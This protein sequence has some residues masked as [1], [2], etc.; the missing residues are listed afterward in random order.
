M[1]RRRERSSPP[2]RRSRA[3][4]LVVCYA[5]GMLA[6]LLHAAVTDHH[7]PVAHDAGHACPADHPASEALLAAF[8]G[9]HADG[10]CCHLEHHGA[11]AKSPRTLLE[12]R[13]VQARWAA[14]VGA[15]SSPGRPTG[16][17]GERE[18]ESPPPRLAGA[19]TVAAGRAPPVDL[20]V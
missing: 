18:P 9:G 12:P 16:F 2:A 3:G 8:D 20:P 6:T 11:A 1:R 7:R 17:L 10:G 14:V 19:T 13:K 4:R 5:I 15:P